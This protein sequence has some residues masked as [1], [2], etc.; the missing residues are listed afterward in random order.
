[1]IQNKVLE[2][3]TMKNVN[4]AVKYLNDVVDDVQIPS[5]VHNNI[6]SFTV[7]GK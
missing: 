2:H 4:E 1:M 6:V 3:R 7:G 5:K